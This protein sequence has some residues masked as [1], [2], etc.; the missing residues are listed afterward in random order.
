MCNGIGEIWRTLALLRKI[1]ERSFRPASLA[2]Y[3]SL[4]ET[5]SRVLATRLLQNPQGWTAHVEL[6]GF[7]LICSLL[8]LSIIIRIIFPVSRANKCL[9]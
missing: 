9:L 8:R 5:R 1:V 2:A 4:Q 3:N 7:F 6:S